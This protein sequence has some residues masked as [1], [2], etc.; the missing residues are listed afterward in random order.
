METLIAIVNWICFTGLNV[1]LAAFVQNSSL[2]V[3]PVGIF[4]WKWLQYR[5]S[6]TEGTWDD[7]ALDVVGERIGFITEDLEDE[8]DEEQDVFKKFDQ[9]IGFTS[10]K[11][12]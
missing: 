4:L 3:I 7:E 6:L 12:E 11:T 5:A 2:I 9:E 8:E 1:H 10:N